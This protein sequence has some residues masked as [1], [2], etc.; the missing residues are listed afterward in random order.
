MLKRQRKSG[1]HRKPEMQT[2]TLR[3]AQEPRTE[4]PESGA[5]TGR[6]TAAFEVPLQR[7]TLEMDSYFK[8]TPENSRKDR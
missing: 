7:F 4:R 8:A 6:A 3:S 5:S 2:R 1:Q